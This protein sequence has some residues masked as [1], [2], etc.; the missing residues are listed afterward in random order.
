MRVWTINRSA[1]GSAALSEN[2]RAFKERFCDEN[3]LISELLRHE[4]RHLIYPPV[5]DVGAGLGDVANAAFPDIPAILLDSEPRSEPVVPGHDRVTSEFFE[6]VNAAPATACGTVLFCHVLQYL[7]DDLDRL[8]S[9]VNRLSPKSVIA[10]TNDNAG[11]F[12]ALIEW[13]EFNMTEINPEY[14]I[15]PVSDAYRECKSTAF[16]ATAMFPDFG[17]M[18]EHFISM[19]LDAE[20][21]PAVMREME[22]QLRRRLERPQITLQQTVRAY[23]QST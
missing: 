6:Y 9:A 10:V 12:G 14:P 19:F 20:P 13:A 23:E 8:H 2:L 18:A 1:S 3:V 15:R 5:L 16:T 17:T 7:D 4:Y 22:A 11:E 21:G